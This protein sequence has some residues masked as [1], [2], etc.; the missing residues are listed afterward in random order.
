MSVADNVGALVVAEPGALVVGSSTDLESPGQSSWVTLHAMYGQALSDAQTAWQERTNVIASCVTKSTELAVAQRQLTDEVSTNAKLRSALAGLR[1]AN[2]DTTTRAAALAAEVEDLKVALAE[3]YESGLRTAN[4]A[5]TTAADC[6]ETPSPVR[7]RRAEH[8]RLDAAIGGLRC[9]VAIL[10]RL[11]RADSP[12]TEDPSID[13][14]LPTGTPLD[15][16]EALVPQLT[17]IS[18]SLSQQHHAAGVERSVVGSYCEG[19]DQRIAELSSCNETLRL[20]NVAAEEQLA[21]LCASH[22]AAARDAARAAVEKTAARLHKDLVDALPSE[23]LV[24]RVTGRDDLKPETLKDAVRIVGE[25]SSCC[26]TLE[27]ALLDLRDKSLSASADARQREAVLSGR[28]ALLERELADAKTASL[29][30]NIATRGVQTATAETFDV[31][32]SVDTTTVDHRTA[33]YAANVARE[34]MAKW[35]GIAKAA[36]ARLAAESVRTARLE[37]RNTDI[38]TTARVLDCFG[39]SLLYGQK[40]GFVPRSAFCRFRAV[41]HAVRFALR[42]GRLAASSTGNAPRSSMRFRSRTELRVLPLHF[43]SVTAGEYDRG[44]PPQTAITRGGAAD[45]RVVDEEF[46][47]ISP[48]STMRRRAQ[49][50]AFDPAPEQQHACH[51]AFGWDQ[52]VPRSASLRS[53]PPREPLRRGP[54]VAPDSPPRQWSVSGAHSVSHD[55]DDDD[56]APAVRVITHPAATSALAADVADDFVGDSCRWK[57]LPAADAVVQATT[58]LISTRL[59]LLPSQQPAMSDKW[60]RSAS[61]VGAVC[62]PHG[63]NVSVAPSRSD[64]PSVPQPTRPP[65]ATR[66]P[67]VSNT[68]AD[69]SK[70]PTPSTTTR[71]ASH[72]LPNTQPVATTSERASVDVPVDLTKEI[73]AVITAMDRSVQS[74]LTPPRKD[75]PT[76]PNEA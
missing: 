34:A 40:R 69:H 42:V 37:A 54:S 38:A 57:L 70:R 18:R 36:E 51:L 24:R 61:P 58:R 44:T 35:E 59:P 45:E 53:S 2:L 27:H 46:P 68:A 52:R 66:R 60:S 11:D 47:V 67:T 30:R 23:A 55:V 29:H 12:L 28:V 41:G 64:S 26:L 33:V 48:P 6:A 4:R 43:V 14:L 76:Q 65:L 8:Y 39:H 13:A 31:G 50:V 20:R 72:H 32:V 73:L 3:A 63:L 21:G 16:I 1:R 9:A 5:D 17:R 15:A 71:P 22:E 49:L 62:G 75:R 10:A 25:L 7:L 19:S 74:A 56:A